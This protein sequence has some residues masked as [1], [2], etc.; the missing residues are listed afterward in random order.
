MKVTNKKAQ[1]KRKEK[2]KKRKE[3]KNTLVNLKIK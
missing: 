1:P 3:K 2:K